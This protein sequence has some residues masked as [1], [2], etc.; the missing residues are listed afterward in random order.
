MNRILMNGTYPVLEFEAGDVRAFASG[1]GTILDADRLP[2]FFVRSGKIDVRES[3]I[4]EWWRRRAIPRTRDGIKRVLEANDLESTDELLSDSYGLSLSDQY[5]VKSADSAAA[6]EHINFFKNPF[7]ERLGKALFDASSSS[8]ITSRDRETPDATSAGDLPKRWVIDEDGSRLLIKGGRTGQE[9]V[10]ELIA[11]KLCAALGIEHVP[12]KVRKLDNRQVSVC[13]EMLLPNE[14][15]ISAWDVIAATKRS[16][17]DSLYQ[18]WLHSAERL[19]VDG[20][21]V[22]LPTHDWI[23]AD[24]I[25]RNTDRHWNNFGLIRNV[26]TLEVRPSPLYDSGESLWNRDFDV[27][28]GDFLARPFFIGGKAQYTAMRQL[29]L[30]DDW[31]KHDLSK[32]EGW[33]AEVPE[34]LQKYT[35][36]SEGRIDA[37]V[38]GVEKQ[39]E[40]LSAVRDHVFRSLRD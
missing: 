24:F 14:E 18:H 19:G 25:V 35:H 17:N 10:N 37:V 30:I 40:A 8:L 23:L 27:Q 39:I 15:L 29:K 16:N 11:S 4:N 33:V 2:V 32:A 28:H 3:V 31:D 20:A 6:W 26:D 34:L 36:L 38:A 13:K 22:K 9:P 5:W 12:Y 7:D 1:N 21:A